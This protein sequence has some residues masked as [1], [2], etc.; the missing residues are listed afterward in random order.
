[1]SRVA[2]YE[3]LRDDLYLQTVYGFNADRIMPAHSVD[4]IPRTGHFLILH[5][6]EITL[7][8]VVRPI[9]IL[10]VW[11][12]RPIERSTE[13]NELEDIL[14]RVQEVLEGAVHFEAS[15]G[16]KLAGVEFTG[17]SGDL[18]DSGYNTI[19]RNAGFEVRKTALV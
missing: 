12:H 13:F 14:N 4:T 18:K 6:E 10:T 8:K 17:Q 16:S 11:A 5:W 9:Q 2:V 7:A 15:D 19:T 3:L 1:M